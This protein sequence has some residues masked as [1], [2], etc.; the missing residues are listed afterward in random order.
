VFEAT[1]EDGSKADAPAEVIGQVRLVAPGHPPIHFI[2]SYESTR[3]AANRSYAVRGR[4]LRGA[5]LM[6]VT[7]RS[8]PVLTRGHGSNVAL[9]MRRVGSTEPA[10]G[11]TTGK[12]HLLETHTPG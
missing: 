9:M 8:Y 6:F 12:A 7:D 5:Q 3:I 11:A 10:S 4:I 1:L 2:I